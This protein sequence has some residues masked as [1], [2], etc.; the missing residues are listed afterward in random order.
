MLG[1]ESGR[2]LLTLTRFISVEFFSEACRPL[3]SDQKREAIG[4]PFPDLS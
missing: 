1:A 3:D 2:P 4:L